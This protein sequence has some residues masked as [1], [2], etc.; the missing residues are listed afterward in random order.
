LVNSVG[1]IT[2]NFFMTPLFKDICNVLTDTTMSIIKTADKKSTD[3]KIFTNSTD[4]Q[5][6]CFRSFFF[7]FRTVWT[8]IWYYV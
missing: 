3:N 8:A 5:I 6:L 1:I 2:T 4:S 7:L